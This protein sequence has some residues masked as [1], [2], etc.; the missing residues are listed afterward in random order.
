MRADAGVA[1]PVHEL[2]VGIAC[3]EIHAVFRLADTIT[4]LV[5]GRILATGTPQQVRASAE[6]RAAYFADAIA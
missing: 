6:V 5:A 3:G 1:A 2:H 4:V